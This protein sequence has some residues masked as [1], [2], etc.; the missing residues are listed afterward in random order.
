ME[1]LC[2]TTSE[3]LSGAGWKEFEICL[4]R[5]KGASWSAKDRALEGVRVSEDH[6]LSVRVFHEDKVAF[7]ST[8]RLSKEGLLNLKEHLETILRYAP[9]EPW[10]QLPS[11][12]QTPSSFQPV[13]DQAGLSTKEEDKAKMALSL[14][15]ACLSASPKIEKVRRATLSLSWGSTYLLQSTGRERVSEETGFFASI[16]CKAKSESSEQMGGYSAYA[17]F[18][19]DLDVLQTGRLAAQKACR[20]LGAKGLTSGTYEVMLAPECVADLLDFLASSF[21]LES[22]FK[23]R[24]R[25]TGHKGEP[26][27]S[28]GFTLTDDPHR[29]DMPGSFAHD[30]EGE[31]SEKIQL[32]EAGSVQ[33]FLGDHGYSK[34]TGILAIG[35][36]SRG[37]RSPCSI[38]SSNLVLSPGTETE[39]ALLHNMKRGLYLVD[40][41]G[42]HTAN[43]ITGDFSLGASGFL[44][45]DGEKGQAVQGFAVSGNVWQLLVSLKGIGSELERM[46]HIQAPALWVGPMQAGGHG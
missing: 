9:L 25:L 8:G 46:G 24:S 35:R 41:M 14:E 34:R 11:L 44:I 31:R 22:I 12:S 4:Q 19:K 1:A 32:V 45:E 7:A 37:L 33:G 29:K 16:S 26:I 38:G 40:L 27:A 36:A 43:P 30:G 21:S 17:P 3:M 2:S 5:R 39:A 42:L 13:M 20:L 6:S 10:A 18:L 23:K 28:K 15:E